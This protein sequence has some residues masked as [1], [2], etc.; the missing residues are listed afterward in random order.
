MTKIAMRR[1][2][3][4]RAPA[5]LGPPLSVGRRLSTSGTTMS[6][7]TMM[8]SA[9]DSTITMAVAAE[10][11]PTNAISVIRLGMGRERQRQHEHVAVHVAERKIQQAGDR[12]RQHKQI[13][14]HQ[15]ERE[16][17]GGAADFGF[18]V[19]LDHA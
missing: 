6:L 7:D 15:I 9:T 13:D 3:R 1:V 12:D 4:S 11:P 8:A 16:Q 14:E 17:P 19:V 18:A 10:R 5:S 2:V